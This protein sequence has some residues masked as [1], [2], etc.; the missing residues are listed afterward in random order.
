MKPQLDYEFIQREFWTCKNPQHRH[1]TEEIAKKCIDESERIKIE[2]KR[3]KKKELYYFL[4]KKRAGENMSKLARDLGMS[5][6]NVT[7]LVEKAERIERIEKESGKPY[8]MPHE[9]GVRSYL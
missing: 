9:R 4:E 5:T 6:T 3:W 8:S 7:R 1:R 2:P